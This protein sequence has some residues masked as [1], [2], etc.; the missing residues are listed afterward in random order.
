MTIHTK[1]DF[2]NLIDRIRDIVEKYENN[3]LHYNQYQIYLANGERIFFEVSPWSIAHLL[4][5]RLDYIKSTNLFKN[6]DPSLLLK[7]ILENSYSVYR[8]V[9][10]G[11]LSYSSLF[12][13]F[14]E[15]KLSSFEKI[16]YYFDPNDIEF[17]CKYDKGRTYQLGLEKN[18]FCDY[19][20]AKVD[21]EENLH[22][23]GLI[24]NG[25][26][27]TPMTNLYFPKDDRQF[28]NLKRLLMN[29][30]IT[31]VNNI[32]ISNSVTEHKNN[33]YLHMS[34]KLKKLE[35]LK[36]YAN[37]IKGLTIDTAYD[38]QFVLNGLAMK[39]NKI[40]V[41]KMVCQQFREKIKEHEIF[42]LEQLEDST[43]EQLDSEMVLMVRTYNDEICNVDNS[44]AQKTYSDLLG[45]YKN[46]E[47]QVFLLQQQLEVSKQEASSYF[48]QLQ[49]LEEE[50]S[51][52]K[53]FQNEIFEVVKRQR[54]KVESTES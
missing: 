19:F 36:R 24:R 5:I 31:Y 45:Q 41:Y 40:N 28:T 15:Q 11:R 10:E 14:I 27:Y 47:E 29:Q 48:E 38:L 2:D 43:K 18:Y 7:E 4:G 30:L 22:L 46:L 44:K 21:K 26:S 42:S 8:H 13:N 50:N 49:E 23:L 51:S 37:S 53:G 25:N 16:I 52:Y 6:T 35:G 1:A 3:V 20:I 9:Q 34:L 33:H 17:V 12:S 54:L 39:D 32:S